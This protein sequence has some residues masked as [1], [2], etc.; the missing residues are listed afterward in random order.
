MRI[1]KITNSSKT[2][3]LSNMVLIVGANGTGKTRFLDELHAEFTGRERKTTL[4]D[5][6]NIEHEV[7]NQ[8]K[9]DWE[10][11]LTL[12]VERDRRFWHNPF[13]LL[14][15]AFDGRKLNEGEYAKIKQGGAD[16]DSVLGDGSFLCKEMTHYLPVN[17]RLS[18]TPSEPRKKQEE[19]ASDPLN[20][21]F[22]NPSTQREIGRMLENLFKKRLCIA[23]HHDPQIELRVANVDVPAMPLWNGSKPMETYRQYQ[24]WVD[25]NHIPRADLEGHGVISFLHIMLAYSLPTNKVLMI[26]EPEIH[27]YPSIKRKFGKMLGTLAKKKNKQIICVTHDSDLLQGVFDARC[28][29]T[30]IKLTNRGGAHEI[31]HTSYSTREPLRASHARASYLQIPLLECIIAV[32]GVIDRS[33]YEFVTTEMKLFTEVEYGFITVDGKNKMTIPERIA[34]D[35]NVPHAMIL[36]FDVL[37]KKENHVFWQICATKSDGDLLELIDEIADHLT[38][39]P[40]VKSKGLRA[41]SNPMHAAQCDYA[42]TELADRGV[43]IVPVGEV[44]SWCPINCEKSE[45]PEKFAKKYQRASTRPTEIKA[46]VKRVLDYLSQRL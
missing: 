21:L 42:I 4:W 46:F 34:S 6:F 5:G 36:D 2:I 16:R 14:R 41:V 18:L 20:L 28:D 38:G 26:D 19:P 8:D 30:L 40:D 43:F 7:L 25:D 9:E 45:Y 23:P 24:K 33:V 29:L 44:E 31:D 22:R 27:L 39:L 32:E 35:M 10:K 37:K 1:K 15:N 13:T 17:T 3:E 12:M 11:H